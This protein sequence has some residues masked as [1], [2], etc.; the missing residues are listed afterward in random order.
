MNIG[1]DTR[2]LEEFGVLL[3]SIAELQPK[4]IKSFM[5]RQGTQLKRCTIKEADKKG[6]SRTHKKPKKYK[7]SPHYYDTIKRG[8]VFRRA[9][10]GAYAVRVHSLAPHAHLLEDG[11]ELIKRNGETG[12]RVKAFLVFADS[13]KEFEPKFEQNC[14]K[15]VD[16]VI[17]KI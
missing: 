5:R 2:E 17:E 12:E 1:L 6:I 10:S 3:E 15:F 14:E 13:A 4:E 11:H 9:V 7:D 8:K 16:K